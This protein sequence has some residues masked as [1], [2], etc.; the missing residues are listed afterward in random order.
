MQ[1]WTEP[2]DLVG[3]ALTLMAQRCWTAT[4]SSQNNVSAQYLILFQD[5]SQ[6]PPFPLNLRSG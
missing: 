1:H 3:L 2:V 6:H 4:A 5:E